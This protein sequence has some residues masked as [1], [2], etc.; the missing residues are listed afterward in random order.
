MA[1]TYFEFLFQGFAGWKPGLQCDDGLKKMWEFN[2]NTEVLC[3]SLP[4]N[5]NSPRRRLST[6]PLAL[7]P[8]LEPNMAAE[9][10]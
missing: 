4:D 1:G 8:L 10:C 2:R 9:T 5:L 3:C 7:R 6:V